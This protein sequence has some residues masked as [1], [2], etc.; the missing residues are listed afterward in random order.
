MPCRPAQ[1]PHPPQLPHSPLQLPPAP[2]QG[3]HEPLLV[4]VGLL[5][6]VH[7]L[8]EDV[9]HH[10][11][12][13]EEAVPGPVQGLPDQQG[14]AQG[15]GGALHGPQEGQEGGR[16][17]GEGGQGGLGQG[18][19]ELWGRAGVQ[20][21][22]PGQLAGGQ[23]G[24]QGGE[25]AALEGAEGAVVRR[26]GVRGEPPPALPA[27]SLAGE[28]GGGAGVVTWGGGT[29]RGEFC[30]TSNNNLKLQEILTN[31]SFNV[32]HNT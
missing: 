14:Q 24:L 6:R 20:E 30:W 22:G 12:P 1:L 19:G 5:H 15:G 18:D 16:A 7:Q 23:G 3:G 21:A 13:G 32:I 25:P 2:V 9:L 11:G 8:A 26:V 31:N 17:A 27:L 10:G 29:Y 4:D 28:G